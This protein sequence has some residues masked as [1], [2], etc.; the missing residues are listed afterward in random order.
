MPAIQRVPLG[1]TWRFYQKFRIRNDDGSP[2][3]LSNPTTVTFKYE[4]PV[5]HD[6]TTITYPTGMTQPTTGIFY[7]DVPLT[8][9]GIYRYRWDGDGSVSEGQIQVRPSDMG[10]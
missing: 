7:V 2:G 10:S 1:S 5:S 4:N 9:V 8:T 6:I 3:D